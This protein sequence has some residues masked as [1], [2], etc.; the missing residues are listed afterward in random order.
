VAAQNRKPPSKGGKEKDTPKVVPVTEKPQR[1]QSALEPGRNQKEPIAKRDEGRRNPGEASATAILKQDAGKPKAEE[2]PLPQTKPSKEAEV[3]LTKEQE[4]EIVNRYEAYVE[5]MERPAKGRRMTIAAE[6]GLPYRA[7]LLAVRNGCRWRLDAKDVSRGER[8]V[9]EKSYFRLLENET[10]FSRI[11]EQIQRETGLSHWQVSR[12][13]DLLHDGEDRLSKVPDVSAEQQSALLAE[14][15]AYL[16]APDP[17]EPAL[18]TLIAERTGV[19]PKQAY[20]V[21]LAYRLSRFREK[22]G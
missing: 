3:V 17:P 10:S 18:H 12:Y 15:R 22:L 11:K 5:R 20:K 21:L 4:E 9:V 19:T 1:K 7:V 8:F 16:S 14:Y 2:I 6:M 13:L